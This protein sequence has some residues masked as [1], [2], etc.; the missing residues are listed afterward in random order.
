MG[1]SDENRTS[2]LQRDLGLSPDYDRTRAQ[3][4][5]KRVA[6]DARE[7]AEDHCRPCPGAFCNAVLFSR[8]GVALD[9]S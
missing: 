1:V 4:R 3:T 6:V 5:N 7:S 8:S 2:L 9:D